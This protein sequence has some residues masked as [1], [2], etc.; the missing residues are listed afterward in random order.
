VSIFVSV[1][2]LFQHSAVYGMGHILNRLIIF[3]LIPVYTNTFAKEELGVYTLVYSYIAILTIIYSYGL[4]T[5]FFRFYILDDSPRGR[6]RIFSTAFLTICLS[7]FLFSL[8]IFLNT[9]YVADLVF[10]SQVHR[11]T[12]DLK[13]ITRMAALILFFDSL[14]LMPFLILRAEEKPFQFIFFKFLN[15]IINFACNI[16]FI[17]ILKRGIEGIFVANLISSA[18]TFTLM[19]PIALKHFRFSFHWPTFKDLMTFGLPYLPS[20]LS[21]NLMDTID[22]IILE[23]LDS[24]ETVGLYGPN[25]KLGMF[26][27]LFIT[28]FRFA[29][30]PF[31]LSTSKQEN[32]KQVFQKVFTY[33]LLA[34]SLVFLFFSLFIDNIVRLRVGSFSLLGEEYWGGTVIVPIIFLA[35]IVYAA[36]LNFIIGIYLEKKTKYLPLITGAGLAGNVLGLYALIPLLGFVGAA[37]SRVIA[38][39]IMAGCLYIVGQRLY[40]IRYEWRRIGTMVV[41][42]AG[43]FFLGRHTWFDSRVLFKFL[44]FVSY[45]V[46]LWIARFFHRKELTTVASFIRNPFN[47]KDT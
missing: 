34:C 29:W 3:L 39:I 38:Y 17:I 44:I 5:A 21:V 42:V 26:M 36:Y 35:Y 23:D 25:A 33:V 37:W 2:R 28:A 31:F 14:M 24:I 20:T 8:V 12:I 45:P 6:G 11:L 1:K 9:T 46:W 16:F 4:D 15:V 22:K 19:I 40:P 18:G 27:A 43:L 30:H 47:N 41:V 7:S 13:Y 10:S 32:A